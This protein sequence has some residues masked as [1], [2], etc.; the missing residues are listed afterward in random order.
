MALETRK[1]WIVRTNDDLT[2]GRGRQYI[3]AVCELEAT[4]IRL[5]KNGY[6]QGSDC[7]IDEAELFYIDNMYLE[8]RDVNRG[9]DEDRK[10]EVALAAR[11]TRDAR[12]EDLLERLRGLGLDDEEISLL[13]T[14]K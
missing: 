10:A 9:T 2:E 14:E 13:R 1:V 6:V 5:A 4:A 11:R 12:R 7:P 3:K 8:I